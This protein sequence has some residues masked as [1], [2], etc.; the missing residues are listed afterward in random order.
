MASHINIV[1]ACS[2]LRAVSDLNPI[3][4]SCIRVFLLMLKG[5]R[6]T[7]KKKK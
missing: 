5:N 7:K 2:S 6:M 4:V 3:I 1:S